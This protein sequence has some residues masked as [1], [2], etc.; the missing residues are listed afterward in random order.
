MIPPHQEELTALAGEILDTIEREDIKKSFEKTGRTVKKT[1]A[2][3]VWVDNL[4][5]PKPVQYL[6]SR[7][8]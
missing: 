4:L 1:T 3:K 8:E 5:L 2:R 7:G 6:K